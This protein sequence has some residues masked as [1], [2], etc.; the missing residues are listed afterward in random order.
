[1]KTIL[2]KFNL[3]DLVAFAT[4]SAGL[5]GLCVNIRAHSPS[6]SL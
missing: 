5:P 6:S 1:M 4:R 3:K 2:E